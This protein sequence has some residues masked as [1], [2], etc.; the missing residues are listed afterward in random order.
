MPIKL[1]SQGF[2]LLSNFEQW[3]NV[4]E[5]V[6]NVIQNCIHD[7]K[8][9]KESL[10]LSCTPGAEIRVA[11]WLWGAVTAFTC[12]MLRKRVRVEAV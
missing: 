3:S 10:T 12:K 11:P 5:L 7:M 9:S 1:F 6:Q 8:A 4:L 2:I